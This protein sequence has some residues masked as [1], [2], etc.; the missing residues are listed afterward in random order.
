MIYIAVTYADYISYAKEWEEAIE[1]SD[2]PIHVLYY[3]DLKTVC[4]ILY[5]I[6]N[7]FISIWKHV[8]NAI[9]H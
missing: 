3:E 7:N 5:G 8:L 9:L 1:Q 4:V 6:V 2:L